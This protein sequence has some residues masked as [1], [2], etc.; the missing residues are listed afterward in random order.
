MTKCD[1][2][3]AAGETKK[4]AISASESLPPSPHTAPIYIPI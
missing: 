2:K 1:T 4:E 3:K